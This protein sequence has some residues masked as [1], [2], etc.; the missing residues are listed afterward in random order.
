MWIYG[1]FDQA[2]HE[3]FRPPSDTMLV[4]ALSD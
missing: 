3:K 4:L 2:L 1:F